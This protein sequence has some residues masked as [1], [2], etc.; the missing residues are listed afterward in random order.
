MTPFDSRWI[1][2]ALLATLTFS[3]P[4]PAQARSLVLSAEGG[5]TIS[6]LR[7]MSDPFGILESMK[8]FSAGIGV[9]WPM[10]GSLEIRPEALYVEKGISYGKITN[11]DVSGNPIGK[12]EA[13]HVTRAIEVPVLLRW[14]IPVGWSVRPVLLGGPFV[15]FETAEL[16]K[17]TGNQSMSTSLDTLNNTDYGMV[18]GGGLDTRAG[19]GRVMLEGRYDL[20]LA[21]LGGAVYSGAFS[22]LAGYSF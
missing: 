1:L 11:T 14:A 5:L 4:D 3:E 13:L 16:L 10:G 12:S 18:F 19:P 20:G 17:V 9:G 8:S 6:K 21:D 15:S 22:I 7:N 2:P